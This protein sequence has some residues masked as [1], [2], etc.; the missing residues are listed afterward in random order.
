M[1]PNSS[2]MRSRTDRRKAA[3]LAGVRSASAGGRASIGPA[4]LRT[5][6]A[7]AAV[8]G[9]ASSGH[10]HPTIASA[11]VTDKPQVG[12]PD[13]AMGSAWMHEDQRPG[14]S[15]PAAA[16]PGPRRRRRRAP[17]AGGDL[18]RQ[19]GQDGGALRLGQVVG[20]ASSH[21]R[22]RRAANAPHASPASGSRPTMRQDLDIQAGAAQRG[23][24]GAGLA[25][26]GV[27]D[28]PDGRPVAGGPVRSGRRA[29]ARS[30]VHPLSTGQ[31]VATS[32]CTGIDGCAVGR[33]RSG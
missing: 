25:D 4:R 26:S 6:G 5:G 11:P 28:Q 32:R 30:P 1:P 13:R 22:V 19:R 14:R 29:T 33:R 17:A 8:R 10:D 15:R 21:E 9:W 24:R 27:A 3:P 31:V 7:A 12:R 23:R 20:V 2:T 18:E 16:S